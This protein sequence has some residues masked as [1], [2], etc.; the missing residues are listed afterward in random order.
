M[1]RPDRFTLAWWA[2]LAAV[3]V[4]LCGAPLFDLLGFE[5]A[6]AVSI[7]LS[8]YA[9]HCGVRARRAARRHPWASWA[10][11]SKQA[12]AAALI[13]L[14]IIT[15]NALR[16]Q[17]CDYLEGLAF[18]GL[19]TAAGAVVAAGWGAAIGRF[20]PRRGYPVFV[21]GVLATLALAGW[22]FWFHPPVDLFHPFFGYWPGALYD[23]VLHIDDRLLWSRFEDLAYAVAALAGSAL[24]RAL[25]PRPAL[26]AAAAFGLAAFARAGAT[27][28]AVHRDAE[29]IADA[30]GGAVATEHLRIMHPASWSPDDVRLMSDE[31]E[32][33]YAEL[34]AFFGFDTSRPITVW[35]HP[36]DVTKKRLM[37]ARRVRIAKPWQWAF[38]VHAP[39]IGQ[40]VLVHEMAHVFSA[41]IAEAPHHLSLYR[42]VVPHMPLIEGLAEA[43][44][45]KTDRLDLHQWSAAMQRI[46]VAP[47]ITELLAPAGFYRRNARTAYT[48]CGSF[49][50]YYHDT[51]GADALAAAYR[52]GSFEGPGAPLAALVAEWE[53]FL[54]TQPLEA[55]ALAW[56]EARFDQPSIFGRACAHEIAA[57][58]DAARDATPREALALVERILAHQPG[59][60][61]ARLAR[62]DLLAVLD[63]RDEAEV[64]ARALADDPRAGAVA[65]A[66][67][68]ERVA[69]L[70]ALG[71]D[72]EAARALYADVAA[73]AFERAD[74]RRLAVKRAALDTGL[75]G[76]RAL[77]YLAAPPADPLLRR[78]LLDAVVA[79][80]P[81]W[82]PGRYLRGRALLATEPALG[83]ADLTAAAPGLVDPS[84]RFEVARM[85]AAVAFDAACYALAAERFARLAERDDL[86]LSR[87]ERVGLATWSRRARFFAGR[88]R[89]LPAACADIDTASMALDDAAGPRE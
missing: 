85:V 33:A 6:F 39:T 40:P 66:E 79:A 36:D 32:F 59:D 55:N 65:R 48:L 67:A 76:R 37:G 46:G 41:E 58:R 84:L 20:F 42:G 19:I 1:R 28:H 3:A 27:R 62:I 22:R 68:R 57:L 44:T 38:H 4:A 43:A 69:D 7:P 81:G 82:A 17:N 74:L 75:A 11:A 88:E 15:A 25:R 80:D 72:G 78:A 30:L 24:P 9:G 73:T 50:R 8:L 53:A 18:Y 87:G 26:A 29:W 21:A 5:F 56:A 63:R 35:I 70:V 49:A 16:V 52:Q 34:R 89:P 23:D 51:R 86:A 83:L 47:P 14:V 77:E 60:V 54:A 13:P 10:R 45:W 2:A 71:G 12:L 31:L 61:P 64:A